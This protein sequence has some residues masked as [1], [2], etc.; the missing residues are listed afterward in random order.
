MHELAALGPLVDTDGAEERLR[1]SRGEAE[2]A[3]NPFRARQRGG[4]HERAPLAPQPAA[5]D[6]LHPFDVLRELVRELHHH[7][8]AE[9]V[10]DEGGALDLQRLEDVA[11]P[12]RE[13]ADRVVA[14]EPRRL[15]VPG[16]IRRDDV[17][18]L[19]QLVEDGRP[20]RAVAGDAVHEH[21]AR[22]L[23]LGRRAARV[24][25]ATVGG[26]TAV[27]GDG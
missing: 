13:R 5:A 4:A 1:T 20:L 27:D 18:L 2:A 23:A 21:D 22:S 12:G 11:Q 3:E 26:S 7:A 24:A 17:V 6:E 25:G 19:R 14:A 15:A 9:R 8:A 16:E 10:T